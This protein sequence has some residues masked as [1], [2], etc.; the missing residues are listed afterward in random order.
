MNRNFKTSKKKR[1]NYIY[2][3]EDGTKTV[4]LPGEDG[5]TE[6]EI[7]ILHALDD[8]EFDRNRKE[9]RR[10]SS[11]DDVSDKSKFLKDIYVDVED[12]VFTNIER[13]AIKKIIHKALLELKPQ[14]QDLINSLYLSNNPMSQAE[15][16]DKLG[17]AEDSV[18]KKALRIRKKLKEIIEKNI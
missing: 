16:A 12:E 10:H 18:K 5:V 8:D 13:K 15:Y 7:E 1:N 17:I 14:Q 11:I 3:K 9:T 4:L 6:V 2:Y